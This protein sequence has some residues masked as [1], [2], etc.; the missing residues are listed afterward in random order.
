MTEKTF[1]VETYRSKVRGLIGAPEWRWRA[2]NSA[3]HRK[4]AYGE[5]YRNEGDMRATIRA[6]FGDVNIR[7]KL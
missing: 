5:S 2:V 7:S 1:H 3:N 4:L 6:L